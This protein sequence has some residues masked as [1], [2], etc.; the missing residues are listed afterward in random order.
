MD[1]QNRN[2]MPPNNFN[3]PQ[4]PNPPNSEASLSGPF[5]TP[6]QEPAPQ[7]IT[8]NYT[9]P[10]VESIDTS[11]EQPFTPNVTPENFSAM[12]TSIPAAPSPAVTTGQT[13][14]IEPFPVQQDPVSPNV[15]MQKPKSKWKKPVT[16]VGIIAL[17]SGISAVLFYF[18]YW[19]RNDVVYERFQNNLAKVITNTADSEA[20]LTDDVTYTFEG[21][22][23]SKDSPFAITGVNTTSKGGND[24]NLNVS[25][26]KAKINL[27]FVSL[28]EKNM[29]DF[30]IKWK[31]VEQFYS[32]LKQQPS[33]KDWSAAAAPYVNVLKKYDDKW[34]RLD[35]SPLLSGST[36]AAPEPI[37]VKDYE[38]LVD[39]LVPI[40]NDRYVGL[41]KKNAIFSTSNIKSE[42]ANGKDCWSYEVKYNQAKINDMIDAMTK[43][44]DTTTLSKSNKK[45]V[46]DA[47]EAYKKSADT[48]VNNTPG[49]STTTKDIVWIDKLTGLPIKFSSTTETKSNNQPSS[50]NTLV[51]NVSELSIAKIKATLKNTTR[52]YSYTP[53]SF[54]I[55]TDKEPYTD[56]QVTASFVIDNVNTQNSVEIGYDPDIKK[57]N[58]A[59]TGTLKLDKP[60]GNVTIS[61]P[62]TSVSWEQLMTDLSALYR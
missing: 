53:T 21:K 58:D 43:A 38:S 61:K 10:P 12:D 11:P 3:P 8:T 28:G 32:V 20:K 46:K 37:T 44:V 48:A 7:Q 18:L 16:I 29:F 5:M 42:Y 31:G 13:P 24:T 2:P 52:T 47:L 26:D 1:E 60:K 6:M 35:L 17:L 22:S 33:S 14:A 23:E 40:F 36:G 30:Y 49:D 39:A 45:L 9:Q 4:S 62:A 55:T 15:F 19:T 27:S 41:D 59:F 34:I 50:L 56:S 57:D 54:S 25:L 51:F